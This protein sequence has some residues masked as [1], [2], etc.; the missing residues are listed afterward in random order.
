VIAGG[1]GG[2]PV[3]C[4]EGRLRGI[5]AV[6]DKDRASALLAA[7]LGLARLII[8]TDADAVYLDY[9]KPTQRRLGRVTVAE[10]EAHHRAGQFPPGTMGPKIDSAIRFLRGGG[11]EV[12]IT[13]FDQL[14]GAVRGEAGTQITP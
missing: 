9:R 14:L 8:S 11:R 3:V 6:V 1:G 5:E 13:C 2:I 12:I 10:M 4:E 7:R